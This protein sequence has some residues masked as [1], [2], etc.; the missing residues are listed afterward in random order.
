MIRYLY[1]VVVISSLLFSSDYLA[2]KKKY[3]DVAIEMQKTAQEFFNKKEYKKA[4]Q[5]FGIE[6]DY[7][8]ACR[9]KDLI[10]DGLNGKAQSSFEMGNFYEAIFW[11]N[12]S[13]YFRPDNNTSKSLRN[14]S[15]QQLRT[16]KKPV[17]L[18]EYGRW[19]GIS[20][21]SVLRLNEEK[22]GDF[23]FKLNGLRKGSSPIDKYGPAAYG[24]LTGK[25][26][27]EEQGYK[28]K[29]DDYH[30]EFCDLHLHFD[31]NFST[32]TL[33]GHCS[34][35][36]MGLKAEGEYFLLRVLD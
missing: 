21:V 33:K 9:D 36:G 35:G 15:Q 34:Y 16:L 23:F 14:K 24:S 32:V 12:N 30:E 28:A 1:L 10:V 4:S 2:E 11:A 27:K 7:A 5:Y 26:I 22:N 19:E 31:H 6:A 29:F 18:G 20:T 17:S 13:L 3:F 25:F 8:S